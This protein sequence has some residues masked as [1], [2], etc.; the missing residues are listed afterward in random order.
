MQRTGQITGSGAYLSEETKRNWFK[1]GWRPNSYLGE[2]GQYHSIQGGAPF[3]TI[4]LFYATLSEMGGF[5]EDDQVNVDLATGSAILFGDIVLDQTFARGLY[6]FLDAFSEPK[7]WK[8]SAT[9]RR[10]AGSFSPNWIRWVRRIVDDQKREKNIGDFSDRLKA[11]FMDR[12]PGLSNKL[13]PAVGYFGDP[14]EIGYDA[15]MVFPATASHRDMYLFRELDRNGIAMKKPPPVI[16]LGGQDI[17]LNES[18][19][20]ERGQG[21]SYYQ[22]QKFLGNARHKVLSEIMNTSSYQKLE[23]GKAGE[24]GV[25]TQGNPLRNRGDV[26]SSKMTIARK[27]AL[28]DMMDFYQGT[29]FAELVRQEMESGTK[30]VHPEMPHIMR[31]RKRQE[32][33]GTHF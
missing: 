3:T 15:M 25:D 22:W 1:A 2:D 13:A 17:D 24:A 23:E 11:E 5:Y 28:K 20:D 30:E 4:M 9:M 29:D 31:E 26:L 6:E 21:Y 14:P 32:Q 33:Q 12:I 18:L 8:T 27:I 19:P 10:L 16:R 7:E